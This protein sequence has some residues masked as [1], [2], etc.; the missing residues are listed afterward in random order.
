MAWHNSKGHPL[1]QP[2]WT[3]SSGKV[4]N[5]TWFSDAWRALTDHE[6][7]ASS[8]RGLGLHLHRNPHDPYLLQGEG[9]TKWRP[10]QSLVCLT[11]HFDGQ[12]GGLK[13]VP[14]FH[15]QIDD[16]FKGH[17]AAAAAGEGGEF[18]R[19]NGNKHD[20]RLPHATAAY[21]SGADTR[22]VVYTGFLPA[23]RNNAA[24][25]AA[26]LAAIDKNIAPPAYKEGEEVADRDW[27][28]DILS[29]TQRGLL[30]IGR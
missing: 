23:T 9:L 27:D 6:A 4:A 15:R 22:E 11:D 16:Y 30:G 13:V 12:S 10:I 19:L 29:A 24:Y 1:D 25:V 18:C 8:F 26:Q 17:A 14:G 28:L 5:R 7:S 20:N 21:L 3:L 2:L